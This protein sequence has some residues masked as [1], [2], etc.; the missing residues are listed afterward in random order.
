MSDVDED[1]LGTFRLK[2]GAESP[3]IA[4]YAGFWRR[5]WYE[6]HTG[7]C[8]KLPAPDGPPPDARQARESM[9]RLI[10]LLETACRRADDIARLAGQGPSNLSQVTRLQREQGVEK[11]RLHLVG[12]NSSATA[13]VT[14]AFLRQ[15]QSDNVKGLDRLA[16]HHAGAYRTYLSRVLDI[17]RRLFGVHAN[18]VCLTPDP[19]S[20]IR[21]V[22]PAQRVA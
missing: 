13:P 19:G 22:G 12:I 4:W 11:E 3:V 10:V 14:A 5:Y 20:N 21:Q 2:V 1:G 15:L 8:S 9:Q 7:I 6:T 16:R 18:D 17:E